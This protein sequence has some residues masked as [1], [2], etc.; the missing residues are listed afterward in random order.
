M[1]DWQKQLHPKIVDAVEKVL[2]GMAQLGHPMVV[3][4]SVRSAEDQKALFAK[5]RTAPGKIVTHADGVVKKSKHQ[6]GADGFGHA[7][8]C[9]FLD[10][11]GQPSWDLSYPWGVYGALS[12]FYGLTWG[13]DWTSLKDL[14]HVE[15]P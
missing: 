7:V 5:G 6:I 2:K 3:T 12:K 4:A 1:T 10:A 14:P 9:A 8:D 15:W 11:H 13:G